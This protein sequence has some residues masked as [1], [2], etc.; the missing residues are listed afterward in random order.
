MNK[1]I[2]ALNDRKEMIKLLSEEIRKI[3]PNFINQEK[4]IFQLHCKS[5]LALR[6]MVN[7]LQ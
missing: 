3:E 7:E 5:N 4:L 2:Q 6:K 1:E